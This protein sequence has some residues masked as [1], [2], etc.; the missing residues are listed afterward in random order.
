MSSW[1]WREPDNVALKVFAVT[2]E[3]QTHSAKHFLTSSTAQRKH[4]PTPAK[5]SAVFQLFHPL[6]APPAPIQNNID[7]SNT[8][9]GTFYFHSCQSVTINM[10]TSSK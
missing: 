7:V 6:Q 4:E 9:P 1:S 3:H 10:H 5:R 2:K 8:I